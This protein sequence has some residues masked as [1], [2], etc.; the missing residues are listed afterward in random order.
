ML[1]LASF[2]IRSIR[3]W[4]H[5][6]ILLDSRSNSVEH[7]HIITYLFVYLLMLALSQK[8]RRPDLCLAYSK[9][10]FHGCYAWIQDEDFGPGEHP[11]SSQHHSDLDLPGLSVDH[12]FVDGQMQHWLGIEMP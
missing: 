6:K 7:L 3:R 5:T 1:Y 8:P 4:A 2:Q 9:S 11:R 10:R 12:V